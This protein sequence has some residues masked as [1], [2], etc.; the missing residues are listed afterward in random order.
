MYSVHTVLEDK[1]QLIV[2]CCDISIISICM[3]RKTLIYII[4]INI[5]IDKGTA[6]FMQS[7]SVDVHDFVLSYKT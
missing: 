4:L 1:T 6:Q 2:F 3:R 5:H 7:D